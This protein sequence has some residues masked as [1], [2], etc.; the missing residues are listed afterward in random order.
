MVTVHTFSASCLH[1]NF[2]NAKPLDRMQYIEGEGRGEE[3]H[4]TRGDIKGRFIIDVA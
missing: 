3:R 4:M 1:V 2:T